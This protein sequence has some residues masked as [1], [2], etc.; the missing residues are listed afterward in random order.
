M[1]RPVPPLQPGQRVH[2]YRL[3]IKR[4]AEHF[5]V[6]ATREIYEQ[7]VASLPEKARPPSSLGGGLA[8]L[9]GLRAL[10]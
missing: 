10:S 5:G 3:W 2:I 1:W 8:R 6:T 7:A 9:L 4:A